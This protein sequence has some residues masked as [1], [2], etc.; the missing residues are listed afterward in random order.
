MRTL[1]ALPM[2]AA[3]ACAAASPDRLDLIGEVTGAGR[4]VLRVTLFAVDRPYTASTETDFLG[5]FRFHALAPGNYTVS[6]LKN[7]LGATRRTVVVS[8]S[9]ADEK[10]V[11]R[12]TIDYNPAEAAGVSGGVISKNSL[13]IPQRA[14]NKY[15]ESQKQLARQDVEGAKR[16]L[17]AA[18]DLAPQF[19][20]AWNALGM[21]AYQTHDLPEAERDFR[22]AIAA[23]PSAFEPS[24]NLAGVLLSEG[25]FQEALDVN[26]RALAERPADALANVQAGIAYFALGDYDRAEPALLQALHTDP[27]H[28]SKPQLFLADIYLRRGD[29]Q[30]ALRAL[31]DYV[32]RHPDADDAERQRQRI[33][34]LQQILAP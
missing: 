3:L 21:I 31:Q 6:V 4:S 19:T 28:F 20:Q 10:G 14:R 1:L 8:P 7:S 17:H 24:A 34:K 15:S 12:V 11:V 22:T 32:A 27:A 9:L 30:A 5:E 13:S 2:C 18:L 33:Q 26:K 25:K 29:G 23:E 16:S